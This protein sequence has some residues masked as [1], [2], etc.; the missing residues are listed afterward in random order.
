MAGE[1]YLQ[2]LQQMQAQMQALQDKM[3][4]IRAERGNG[5]IGHSDQS[6]NVATIHSEDEGDN[7][8]VIVGSGE[9]GGRAGGENG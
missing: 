8:L 2:L 7:N 4:A 1:P 3:A 5:M 9:G 6:V